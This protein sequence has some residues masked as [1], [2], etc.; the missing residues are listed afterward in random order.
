MWH[1]ILV[2]D[3]QFPHILYFLSFCHFILVSIFLK[4]RV[5]C[6]FQILSRWMAFYT[7][8]N[9]CCHSMEFFTT[10]IRLSFIQHSQKKCQSVHQGICCHLEEDTIHQAFTQPFAKS[11]LGVNSQLS[12]SFESSQNFIQIYIYIYVCM[13]VCVCV[14]VLYVWC[15]R[16]RVCMHVCVC[17][18]VWYVCVCA[19]MCV[20]V[21]VCEH[22]HAR[23]SVCLCVRVI[24]IL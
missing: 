7:E 21:H 3:T 23:V 19:L 4:L 13:C 9:H 14:C 6:P 18:C 2:I 20:C 1:I 10:K 24:K 8:N 17:V 22:V 16:A 15:K 12:L 11:F 5:P